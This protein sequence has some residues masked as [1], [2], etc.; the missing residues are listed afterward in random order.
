MWIDTWEGSPKFTPSGCLNHFSG[1]FLP[2]LL[3][4]VILL[5]CVHVHLLASMESSENGYGWEDI[6]Y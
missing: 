1:A 5:P 3:W 2:G 4:P 6:T